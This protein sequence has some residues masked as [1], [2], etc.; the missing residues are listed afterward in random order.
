MLG[1]VHGGQ[2]HD[3]RS[4]GVAFGSFGAA[5]QLGFFQLGLP[6]SDLLIGSRLALFG[7]LPDVGVRGFEFGA[8]LRDAFLDAVQVKLDVLLNGGSSLKGVGKSQFG[9]GSAVAQGGSRLA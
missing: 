9:G 8:I 1:L 7:P 4:G 6:L 5:L 3:G 2:C